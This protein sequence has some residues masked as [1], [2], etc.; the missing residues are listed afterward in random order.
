M[1]RKKQ[2]LLIKTGQWIHS[3]K[4]AGLKQSD[5]V[6]ATPTTETPLLERILNFGS[7]NNTESKQ[8][9][10]LRSSLNFI[11]RNSL[12]MFPSFSSI[13]SNVTPVLSSSITSTVQK[14]RL[15]K[16]QLSHEPTT[17]TLNYLGLHKSA[18][19]LP[20]SQLN[21]SRQWLSNNQTV[22]QQFKE[23][24]FTGIDRSAPKRHILPRQPSLPISHQFL[25]SSQV[26]N[27]SQPAL[28]LQPKKVPLESSQII[29]SEACTTTTGHSQL[30]TGSGRKLP[31]Q[32]QK[33]REL[34][35][36]NDI[37]LMQTQFQ[38]QQQQ[39]SLPSK[40]PIHVKL[41]HLN[42]FNLFFIFRLSKSYHNC[43][44]EAIIQY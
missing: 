33:S 25:P 17:N 8:P 6:A 11:R 39:S 3:S 42:I 43:R 37:V 9:Q 13:N 16:R 40:L 15:L 26:L 23:D 29:S 12:G 10:P 4:N 24:N 38:E 34:P 36:L 32:R 27:Q 31:T 28:M 30:T 22:E 21:K 18:A 35:S 20:Q 1:C 14:P 7:A 19:P 44:I 41:I 5:T 2:E